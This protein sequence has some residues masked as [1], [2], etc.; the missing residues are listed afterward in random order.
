MPLGARQININSTAPKV[1]DFDRVAPDTWH[2]PLD[3]AAYM[4]AHPEGGRGITL[5]SDTPFVIVV[6]PN[7]NTVNLGGHAVGGVAIMNG[8]CISLTG[9]VAYTASSP[10]LSVL[11]TTINGRKA[12]SSGRSS[13]FT[14]F[15]TEP[16]DTSVWV[17][18]LYG[19]AAIATA[20]K[21]AFVNGTGGRI[22]I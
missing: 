2:Y 19:G 20:A 17:H 22:T 21:L 12:L 10:E 4:L 3:A 8:A 11:T 5:A 9:N 14:F 6:P 18:S 1:P 16:G 7:V 15:G 13:L